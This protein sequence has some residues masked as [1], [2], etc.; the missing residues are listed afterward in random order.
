MT[1]GLS[2]AWTP[3]GVL[4]GALVVTITT[5][6]GF[7][8]WRRSGSAPRVAMLE[9]LRLVIVAMVVATLN[10]PEWLQPY[11]PTQRPTLV[12]LR[13]NSDSMKTKDV[14]GGEAV[15]QLPETRM[16]RAQR[17]ADRTQ[18]TR[19]R[20]KLDVIVEPFSSTLGNPS[21]GTDLHAALAESAA[22]HSNLRAVVLISDG[23]WNTGQPPV[24]AASQLKIKG[25][26]VY[27]I[28]VGSRT[29]MPDLDLVRVDA[30]TFGVAGK[31]IR[32][33]F[34]IDSMLPRDHEATISL[35]PSTG[36]EVT[37]RLTLPAMS[38]LEETILWHPEKTGTYQLTL[39]VPAAPQELITEN[40]ERVVP[41]EV[42]EEALKVLLVESVPRWEYRYV[43]NALERDSGVDVSC[44]LFHPGLSKVG[45]G[46][47]YIKAFPSSMDELS[48][49]DVLFLGDVGVGEGQLTVEQ[50]RL[51]KGLVE[52][53]ASGLILMP[54]LQGRQLSLAD[55]ELESLYPV[56]LDVT[57]PHG[58]G[59]RT[60]S[61][62][63][64]TSAGRRSLLTRLE[65][66]EDANAQ[67][68]ETLPGFQW[69]AAVDRA[70]V[71]SQVL[72][73]HKTERNQ[74]GRLPLLVTRTYGTGKVL[75]MGTDGAWRWR[76][77]VE[78]KYHY[79]FW[80]QV[81]RWMAYQRSMASGE[82]MRLYFTPDRPQASDSVT[83]YANVSGVGGEPLKNGTV[84]LRVV[85]PSGTSESVRLSPRGEEWG[86][87]S[88]AYV[89]QEHGTYQ[90]TLSCR[91]NGSTLET[92]LD[93]QGTVQEKMGRP[94]RFDVLQEL[95]EVTGGKLVEPAEV[96][97]LLE[98]IASLPDPEP[99]IRRLRLWCHPLWA[100][101]LVF[102]LAIF[103]LGRKMVG[104][105]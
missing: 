50:C 34:V 101:I 63:E 62:F 78:D 92:T 3:W 6:L 73:T 32:I 25:I 87:F 7:L 105:V 8:A 66:S 29:Q 12:V 68:W 100:G 95:A 11:R 16:D 26:P 65:D 38:R 13:D 96:A 80:G 69:Y 61:Q 93:V 79:R 20:E 14:V 1:G 56:A 35:T 53:Q 33:P 39:R 60:A 75:F 17:L 18:W 76:E 98:A 9:L 4:I 54:G 5:L 23:D 57:Q 88:S 28:G 83:F 84:L 40:N 99:E 46:H 89:P 36:Q 90:L 21:D 44:L 94:A 86:L 77:G 81:A 42:R 10:Q 15:I 37:T 41:I 30:P 72:A 85:S 64:L 104:T 22:E 31:P 27:C 47:G 43:R 48:Q 70:K 67:L 2:L 55:T 103:W 74:Y 91:E 97:L 71:N 59:S 58:W 102:L 24:R 49:Y 45:G 52:R 51:I 19:L 82:L